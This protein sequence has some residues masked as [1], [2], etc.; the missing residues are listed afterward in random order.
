LGSFGFK[1]FV[2]YIIIGVGLGLF[3]PLDLA[4]SLNRKREFCAS[5]KKLVEN[6]HLLSH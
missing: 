6:P 2:G 4:L 3:G 1:F 5:L